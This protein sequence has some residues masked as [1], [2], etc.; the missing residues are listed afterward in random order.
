[1]NI[2]RPA[3]S[4][5]PAEQKPSPQRIDEVSRKLESQ[6]TQMLVKCMRD[7]SLG[8]PMFPE[9]NQTYRDLY[10]R[11]LSDLLSQGKGLGLAPLIARQLNGGQSPDAGTQAGS[12]GMV[13]PAPSERRSQAAFYKRFPAGVASADA[14]DA[15]AGRG[16]RSRGNAVAVDEAA[17]VDSRACDDVQ[18]VAET[19][20]SAFPAGSPEHFVARIWPHARRAAKELGVD[21]RAL[22]A[23]AAL[24]TGW[25]RRGIRDSAGNSA[26]N[27]FGIKA[28]GW[29]G[30]RVS[31]STHEYVNGERRAERADFRAYRSPAESFDDYVRL[32]KSNPRYQQALNAG[33]DVR[34][35]A[36]ELQRAGYATDPAYARKIYAI[37][38][39]PTLDR[40]LST[41]TGN[42]VASR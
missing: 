13:D 22:V 5:A 25:G 37:A 28:T 29:Q 4:L 26:N 14:L 19:D 32:L 31:T 3:F 39:G 41:A 2:T 40:A 9:Q 7:A 18:S 21:P 30:A 23:Q 1:M 42:L 15:I 24:E 20:P 36:S 8:D 11:Q 16:D 6:F 33:D 10:D 27:L 35:F 17:L 38:N 12:D 34:R